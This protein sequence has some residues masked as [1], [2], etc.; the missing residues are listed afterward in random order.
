[1]TLMRIA[2]TG[3]MTFQIRLQVRE[4]LGWGIDVSAAAATC[5]DL[6]APHSGERKESDLRL[7]FQQVI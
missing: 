4:G 5:R 7:R 2:F 6:G 1:M 3:T